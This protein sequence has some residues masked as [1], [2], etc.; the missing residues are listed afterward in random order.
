MQH[1]V[2][3]STHDLHLHSEHVQ[4][5]GQEAAE[6][7]R[8]RAASANGNN[9]PPLSG[10]TFAFGL[11]GAPLGVLLCCHLCLPCL[12]IRRK[13]LLLALAVMP[14]VVWCSMS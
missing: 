11:D 7:A 8:T 13:E 2:T 10:A 3:R 5:A 9:E 6:A 14:G 12:I 4:D 1:A